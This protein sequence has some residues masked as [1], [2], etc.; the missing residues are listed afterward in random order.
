MTLGVRLLTVCLGCCVVGLVGT[1][2]YVSAE[3]LSSGGGSGASASLGSS[4][5]T[6]GSPAEG[7]QAQA[8]EQAKLAS[9]EAVAARCARSRK[10]P[11]FCS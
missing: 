3:G 10:T 6:P 2:A 4:L 5:V 7:E 1:P 9:P 11:H 8:Q